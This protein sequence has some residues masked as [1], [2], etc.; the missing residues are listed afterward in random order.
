MANASEQSENSGS[1][2]PSLRDYEDAYNALKIDLELANS[3]K[4]LATELLDDCEWQLDRIATSHKTL[5]TRPSTMV[6]QHFNSD[7]EPTDETLIIEVSGTGMKNT[8]ERCE[9]LVKRIKEL[10]GEDDDR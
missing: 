1:F 5:I 9:E 4:R 6:A 7:G 10:R 3:W 8:I 2:Q